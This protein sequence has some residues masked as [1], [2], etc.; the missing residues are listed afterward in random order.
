[1][2]RELDEFVDMI[3]AQ[4]QTAIYL[5]QRIYRFFVADEFTTEIE[6]NI[7]LPLA[8]TFRNSD[9][10]IE[11]VL[12]ELLTSQHFYEED[13]L[14]LGQVIGGKILDSANL[15]LL[16]MSRL[17]VAIPDLTNPPESFYTVRAGYVYNVLVIGSTG[18]SIFSPPTVA[19]YPADFQAPLWSCNWFNSATVKG[20][21]EIGTDNRFFSC[22]N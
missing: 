19:G 20:R 9:Y 7:I 3:F 6:T 21:F 16:N 11:I 10:N 12:R 14:G 13:A 4:E 17:N 8:E 22:L 5:C 1:M 15:W 2:Y 18:F